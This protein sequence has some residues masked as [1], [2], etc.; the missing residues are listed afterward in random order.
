MIHVYDGSLMNSHLLHIIATQHLD[1]AWLWKRSPDGED[2][3][4]ECFEAV[5]GMLEANPDA[6]FVFSRS[7]AWSFH[8]IQKRWPLLFEKV[9]HH[10]ETGNIELCGGEWVE[11]DH[12]IPGGEALVRQCFYGQMYYL[13]TF[14]KHATVCWVP[15]IFAH[16]ATLPQICAR[17]GMDGYYF[18]RCRPVGR[19]GEPLHQFLWEGPDRQR[20][21]VLSGRW[22]GEPDEEVLAEAAEELERTGLPATHVATG[23]RSDRRITMSP[24]W[25]SRPAELS[26]SRA[27]IRCQW[28]SA[29]TVLDDMRR[30]A[31]QLPVVKGELGFQYTGTYTSHGQLKKA[32]RYLEVLLTD[33]EKLAVHAFGTGD[34]YPA[35]MLREAWR[36]V[37]VNQFHDIA[38][39]CCY[40]EAHDEAMVLFSEAESAARRVIQHALETLL[41][42]GDD[43]VPEDA[44][45]VA[46]INTL[47]WQRQEL[48][49]MPCEA[50]QEVTVWDRNGKQLPAQAVCDEVEGNAVCFLPPAV[51]ALNH[52]TF[53]LKHDRPV[54]GQTVLAGDCWLEN[55]C[56]R[57]EF[58]PASGAL[59][60]FYDKVQGFEYLESGKPSGNRFVFYEDRTEQPAPPEHGWQPW[61]IGYTGRVIEAGD[62]DSVAVVETGPVRGTLRTTRTVQLA[63]SRPSARLVQDCSITADSPL[64]R[65]DTYGDWQ[66]A[67]VLLKSEFDLTIRTDQV[68]AEAPYGVAVR[69]PNRH[70]SKRAVDADSARED[71]AASQEAHPEPDRPM[72]RWLDFSDGMHG[73]AFVNDGKHGY[74]ADESQ[75]RLSLMRAPYMRKE[76]DELVG[77]GPFRFSYAVVPHSGDWR[78][79]DLPR[80]AAGFNHPLMAALVPRSAPVG[81]P[82]PAILK[83]TDSTIHVTALKQAE[84]GNGMILRLFETHGTGDSISLEF[85]KP[86]RLAVEC[87]LLERAVTDRNCAVEDTGSVVLRGRTVSVR[88]KPFEIKTLRVVHDNGAVAT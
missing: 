20:V 73:L 16:S 23:L 34:H 31:D 70:E 43:P 76:L 78:D 8:V 52:E 57:V 88:S 47:G 38:C 54:T 44:T 55:D 65:F 36:K 10:V 82:D 74:D 9:R 66:A 13:D 42:T 1:V 64:V 2:L 53:Y 7:T 21:F 11:P 45:P 77:L 79:V 83:A 14:G 18:H 85:S 32:H 58:D 51:P 80:L 37:C 86:V 61:Y 68:V 81:E 39:G 25:V 75:V 67:E 48:V 24:D 84:D 46:A 33:A 71:R 27:D 29:D 40:N 72:Q 41:A 26:G 35:D 56:V 49:I 5:V 59:T 19:D 30:Y 12:F 63:A 22:V 15:D 50:A 3:M 17:S 60:S 28:S 4:R 6:G 69:P 62:A 87:D